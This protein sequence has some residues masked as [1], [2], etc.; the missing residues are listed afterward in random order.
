MPKEMERNFCPQ[1]GEKLLTEIAAPGQPNR[2]VC[3]RCGL[4]WHHDPKL[5]VATLIVRD[6][7][8][9]LLKRAHPPAKG[10]W[11]LPGGFVD[12]GEVVESAAAREVFEETGFQVSIEKMLGLFSYQAYSVV[13]AIYEGRIINGELTVSPESLDA[14][15]FPPHQIPWPDLAF[16]STTDV[17]KTYFSA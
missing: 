7:K 4:K 12:A 10:Q 17:L 11:C 9:L 16:P 3:T 5:A 15:W 2:S 8:V 13:V 14:Q 6:G 1:C